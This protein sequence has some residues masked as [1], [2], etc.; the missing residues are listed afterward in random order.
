MNN[1]CKRKFH[2]TLFFLFQNVEQNVQ[3]VPLSK[4]LK[5]RQGRGQGCVFSYKTCF[6]PL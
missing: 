2:S 1:N 6:K 3:N 4:F 5:F